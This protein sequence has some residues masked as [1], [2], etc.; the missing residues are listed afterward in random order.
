MP[1]S[2]QSSP[3]A[4]AALRKVAALALAVVAVGLSVNHF[5]LYILLLISTVV[6]FTGEVSARGKPWLAAVAIVVVA[7]AGQL[8]LLPPCIDEGH[9]VFLHGAAGS[10]LQRALPR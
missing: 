8:S 9:N 10:A 5:A 1:L 7:V 2:D 4:G 3:L 6:I